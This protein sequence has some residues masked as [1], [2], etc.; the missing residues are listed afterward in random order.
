MLASLKLICL[1]LFGEADLQV[2]TR[3]FG[4]LASGLPSG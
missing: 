4:Q 2:H 3:M 1:V